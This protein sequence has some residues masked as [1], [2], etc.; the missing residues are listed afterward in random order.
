MQT[1][2]YSP[3][4]HLNGLNL[5]Q[6]HLFLK[7]PKRRLIN[8]SKSSELDR[9]EIDMRKLFT[10]RELLR[11]SAAKKIARNGHF[12]V[13]NHWFAPMPS[14]GD[15]NGLRGW[16]IVKTMAIVQTD[17]K[18]KIEGYFI[19]RKRKEEKRVKNRVQL[20]L[21]CHALDNYEH[22]LREQ[23]GVIQALE[24]YCNLAGFQVRLI[25]VK[26]YLFNRG[27]SRFEGKTNGARN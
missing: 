20:E 17:D 26:G 12:E 15:L 16:P 25:P 11:P 23:K 21:R 9:V 14:P 27:T 22:C 18:G 2:K 7:L 13:H 19:I 6:E 4:E 1:E 8:I 10:I 3:T 24:A 5:Q